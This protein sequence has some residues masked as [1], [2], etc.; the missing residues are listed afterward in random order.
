[1]IGKKKCNIFE[2]FSAHFLAKIITNTHT[3]FYKKRIISS[4]VIV[5]E[6]HV[7]CQKTHFEKN[8]FEKIYIL[9]K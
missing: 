1:M 9:Y 8:S 3:K 7:K 2:I 6:N 5:F 4:K